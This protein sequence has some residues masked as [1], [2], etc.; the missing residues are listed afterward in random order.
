[1]NAITTEAGEGRI[2]QFLEHRR[3]ELTFIEAQITGEEARITT[4]NNAISNLEQLIPM[5]R[6]VLD[7][8]EENLKALR[9]LKNRTNDIL[10]LQPKSESTSE[11]LLKEFQTIV[12][13]PESGND[14]SLE[15]KITKIT[16]ELRNLW[17]KFRHLEMDLEGWRL[18]RQL[19]K[20]ALEYLTSTRLSIA[21]AIEEAKVAFSP[22]WR[23][24]ANVWASI[25]KLVLQETVSDYV[26]AND[27]KT[28]RPVV[29]VLSHVCYRW[30]SLIQGEADL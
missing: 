13:I 11:A 25:F 2:R 15:T 26:K 1:M 19:S 16:R 6:N 4:C 17:D 9:S 27:G 10:N 29:Y 7:A 28:F 8:H 23:I 14:E 21:K 20:S 18:S 30:R 3:K 12:V 22:L 5:A 24:P